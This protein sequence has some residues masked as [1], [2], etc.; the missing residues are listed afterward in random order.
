MPDRSHMKIEIFTLGRL[1]IR[2]DGREVPNF[3]AQPVRTALLVYLAVAGEASRDLV[4]ALLWP[5]SDAPRARHALRQTLYELKRTLGEGWLEIH[6]ELLRV[7]KGVSVD[8]VRFRGAMEM[9]ATRRPWTSTA[10]RFW[11]AGT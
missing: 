5:E 11:K 6:G 3:S 9:P 2:V 1:A 10:G 4:M 7:G 8:A